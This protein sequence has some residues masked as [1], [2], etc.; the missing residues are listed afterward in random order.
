MQDKT[1]L[2]ENE[3]FNFPAESFDKK[4]CRKLQ[5]AHEALCWKNF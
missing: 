3:I 1:I 2:P 5:F 4:F